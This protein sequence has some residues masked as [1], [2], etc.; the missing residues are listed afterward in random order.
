[1]PF[2]QAT[3]DLPAKSDSSPIVSPRLLAAHANLEK[4]FETDVRVL[5]LTTDRVIDLNS[6]P[7]PALPDHWFE[8]SRQVAS[9]GRPE[10]IACDEP[11][12]ALALPIPESADCRHVAIGLFLSDSWKPG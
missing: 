8:L 10:F 3:F 7:T 2:P 1:M 4:W 11:L 12:L 6:E 5:D 9:R